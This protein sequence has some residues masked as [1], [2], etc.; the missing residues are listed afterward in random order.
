MRSPGTQPA[1]AAEDAAAPRREAVSGSGSGD[2]AL[3]PLGGR[4]S[5]GP[6]RQ[7]ALPSPGPAPQRP[8]G[9][10]VAHPLKL[11]GP[12]HPPGAT[13]SSSGAPP[14]E[15]RPAHFPRRV[16]R[17]RAAAPPTPR[18]PG[19]AQRFE[20]AGTATPSE[21]RARREAVLRTRGGEQLGRRDCPASQRASE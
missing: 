5:R 6:P 19:P 16:P 20:V 21:S 7:S 10:A 4:G 12:A 15:G 3:P 1:A 2:L 17:R 8:P 14:L 11:K 13:P 9:S 18:P